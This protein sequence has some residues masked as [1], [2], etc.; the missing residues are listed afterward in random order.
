M[1]NGIG[2]MR[3]SEDLSI[4]DTRG[5]ITDKHWRGV[6]WRSTMSWGNIVGDAVQMKIPRR[7]HSTNNLISRH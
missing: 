4:R 5:T 3:I 2:R 7:G 1:E 6:R